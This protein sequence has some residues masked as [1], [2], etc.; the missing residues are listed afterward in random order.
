MRKQKDEATESIFNIVQRFLKSPPLVVWGSG[1][2]ISFGLPSMRELSKALKNEIKD[3]DASNDNLEDELSK[4][5]YKDKLP[6]IKQTIWKK[7]N[8]AD[9]LTLK[10]LIDNNT[11]DFNGIKLLF[12]K[13][14][15]PH[16]K[17]LNIVTTNY[18]RVLEHLLSYQGVDFTD[19][20]NGKTLST[21]DAANFKDSN[22]VN[23]VKVHGS[24]NWFNVNEKVRY[25]PCETVNKTPKIIAPSRDKFEETYGLPYRELIQ[26]SDTLIGNALS[27]LIVG[28][29]FNDKHLT[30]RIKA[31]INKGIPLVLITKEISKNTFKELENAGKYILFE[32]AE[33]GETKV[34]YK[35]RGS[36]E[37]VEKV[38]EGDFWQLNKFMEI[39]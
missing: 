22:I 37:Q 39:L 9:I 19:G 5:K 16:P 7:V 32:E 1:A 21:F 18:D 11:D 13:F 20:F 25:L 24:L 34:I 10:N 30:P 8:D 17:V 12:E 6:Q 29:G 28:F 4:D 14:I 3:F 38:I 35:E 33:T 27:F 2:T 15:D 31:N 23:L 36:S 26:K